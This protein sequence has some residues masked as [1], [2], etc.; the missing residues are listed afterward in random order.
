LPAWHAQKLD[1]D[2]LALEYWQLLSA[3]EVD[4][5]DQYLQS[6]KLPNTTL[7][8]SILSYQP[9]EDD[10]EQKFWKNQKEDVLAGLGGKQ[11]S[12][13]WCF[14]CTRDFVIS[15]AQW[16]AGRIADMIYKPGVDVVIEDTQHGANATEEEGSPTTPVNSLEAASTSSQSAKATKST[17]TAGPTAHQSGLTKR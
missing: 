15:E 6:H 5:K 3:L 1:D 11:R 12:P 17:E 13:L 16:T 2:H 10:T 7:L 8:N 14:N 9:K 4:T